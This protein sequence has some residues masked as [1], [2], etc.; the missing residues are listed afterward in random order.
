MLTRLAAV[1]NAAY[2]VGMRPATVDHCPE[3][4]PVAATE[5]DS[6]RRFVE[7]AE[8]RNLLVLA[9]YQVVLR[10]GW[11]FKTESIVIPAFLDHVVPWS[12]VS[13]V[14]RGCLPILNRLGH[15][16]PPLL[17]SRRLKIMPLKKRALM[18]TCLGMS[19][20][21]LTLAGLYT[22][23]GGAPRPWMP[24]AFLLLY[25]TFFTCTG[26]NML[27]FNTLQGKLVRAVRRGRLMMMATSLG[28]PLAIVA[29]L[30]LMGDWLKRPDGGFGLLFGFCGT[31][32]CAASLITT[33]LAEPRDDF[34]EPRN[35][36]WRHFTRSWQL[37]REDANFRRL[38]V[39]AMLF[40]TVLMLFPHYQALGIDELGLSLKDLM[41]WVVVQNAGTA[42]FSLVAG[43]LADRRGNRLVVQILILC[44]MAT[45]LLATFLATLGGERATQLYFL[46][47]IPL[48]LTPVT[49]RTM[50]NYTLEICGRED[51]P[52]YVSTLNLCI[53]APIVLFSPLVGLLLSLTTFEFVFLL[54]AGVILVCGLLSMRLIEPR[55]HLHFGESGLGPEA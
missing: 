3:S 15:S 38:A 8:P 48:G 33:L 22:L 52:R 10:M 12:G 6:Q 5:I 44:A 46:V 39:V 28:A 27:A 32:F 20:S 7:Q 24:F 37:V 16:I 4:S 26:L 17:C 53:A 21:F 45:P 31:V 13:S 43:P 2:S 25:A 30:A 9:A 23:T 19:A 1:G 50:N 11:I 34:Q 41:L 18:A 42:I 40:S 49:F 51:H 54:G 35:N 14:L 55:H 36:T 29:A 47:F